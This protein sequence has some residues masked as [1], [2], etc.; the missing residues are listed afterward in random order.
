MKKFYF[1]L[2]LAFFYAG[3]KAQPVMIYSENFDISLDSLTRSPNNR[4]V[5]DSSLKSSYPYA[6]KGLIP[7]HLG[8]SVELITDWIDAGDYSHLLLSFEHICKVSESDIVTVE[9]ELNRIGSRWTKIPMSSYIGL[10]KPY[11]GQK[12]SQRSYDDWIYKD[13]L[14]RPTNSWW[15]TETF[16]ISAEAGWEQFRLKFKI[17]RGT[18]VGTQFAYGWLIDNIQII[19]AN[20]QIKLPEVSFL[21]PLIPD[22]VFSTGPF[23]VNAKVATRTIAPIIHPVLR[24]SYT[25]NMITILDSIIMTDQDGGD[26]LWTATIPQQRFGT[27][28]NYYIVGKDTGG[29]EKT[30]SSATY[31]KR[32][33]PDSVGGQGI[34]EMYTDAR[35]GGSY[36]MPFDITYTGNWTRQIYPASEFNGRSGM[37]TKIGWRGYY[38]SYTGVANRKNVKIYFEEVSYTALTSTAYVN[39]N[40]LTNATLVFDGE[41]LLDN[42]YRPWNDVSLQTPYFLTPGSNLLVHVYDNSGFTCNGTNSSGTTYYAFTYKATTYNSGVYCRSATGTG[43]VNNYGT[44][45]RFTMAS[46]TADS[47]AVAMYAI[48]SPNKSVIAGQSTPVKVTISNNGFKDLTSCVINWSVNGTLQTPYHWTGML[49]D[50]WKDTGIVIGSYIP[51][52]EL[53]DTVVVWVGMPNGVLDSVNVLDDTLRVITYGCINQFSGDYVIGNQSGADFPSFNDAIKILENCGANGDITFKF[54][55][56]VYNPL[57]IGDLKEYI[58]NYSLTITSVTGNAED[59]VFERTSGTYAVNISGT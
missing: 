54:Q 30:I 48:E 42:G 55:S 40:T 16:D 27:L 47:N 13:S 36:V 35:N 31:L 23:V 51:R 3:L 59:V 46:G 21:A 11:K 19:G 1:L 14:A 25:Y 18:T 52:N 7:S 49:P 10:T 50:D 12:F 6:M 29:N 44:H 37:I 45:T 24:I 17:K 39:P 41:I 20:A 43:T 8:D 33:I 9:Y 58:G 4:W 34:V 22:T 5:L 53:Y 15:K 32:F 28:I 26:S 2:V 56:G 38:D 57:A